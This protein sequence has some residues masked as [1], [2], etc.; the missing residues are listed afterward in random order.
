MNDNYPIKYAVLGLIDENNTTFGFIASKCYV[1]E[2]SI[3]YLP[4]GNNIKYHKVVFPYTNIVDYI[5]KIYYD[6]H[7][8]DIGC[9]N[10]PE[11]NLYNAS[12]AMNLF[13]NYED[14]HVEATLSNQKLVEDLISK[15][16]WSHPDYEKEKEKISFIFSLNMTT[17]R[18][19]EELIQKQTGDMKISNK[20]N[21]LINKR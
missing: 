20:E 19:F 14:A 16:P 4:D 1:I 21:I 11:Y 3:R 5:N 15:L 6:Y 7:T 12:I 2:D 10:I 13:D 18:K 17:C 9:R 8:Q